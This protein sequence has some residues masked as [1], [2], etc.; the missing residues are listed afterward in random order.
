[1][2]KV[3]TSVLMLLFA[4]NFAF[5]DDE[6]TVQF[7]DKDGK[8]VADGTTVNVAEGEKDA[9]GEVMFKTGLYVKVATEENVHVGIDYDIKSLPNGAFQ[10]CFPQNCVMKEEAGQYSTEK[11][12]FGPTEKKDIQAE[13]IPDEDGFGT[14]TVE[15]QV[16]AYTYNALTKVYTLAESGPKVTVNMIYKD[17]AS[18]DNIENDQAK[19]ID[20][21]NLSGQ[22][23][24]E[25][26]KGVNIVKYD[27][28]K[29]IKK[30][31]R[32]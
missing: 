8:V 7:V 17:P 11:G 1:M 6:P 3:F 16:N 13:W 25:G 18:V 21:F 12:S 15:L 4:A 14:C 26:Q 22:R 5:A 2:K 10:I 28:G 32:F 24:N 31:K 23:I 19:E 30:V 20:R 29:T 9:F 27:N